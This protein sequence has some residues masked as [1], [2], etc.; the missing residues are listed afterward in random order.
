M[1]GE[2]VVFRQE[3]KGKNGKRIYVFGREKT[4]VILLHVECAN[5]L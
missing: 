3:K 5:T 2:K 1:T 4:T